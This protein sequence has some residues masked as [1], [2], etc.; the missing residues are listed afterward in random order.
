MDILIITVMFLKL[1]SILNIY[2]T[3]F[4]IAKHTRNGEVRIYYG[5]IN[6]LLKK[7]NG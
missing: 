6:V 7:K 4:T 3:L 2:H 1:S 5:L